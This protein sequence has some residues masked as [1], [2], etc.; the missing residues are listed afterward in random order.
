MNRRQFILAS[1]ASLGLVQTCFA[2]ASTLEVVKSPTCGCCDAWIEHMTRAGFRVSAQNLDQEALWKIKADSGISP[3]ISSCHT[4]F[5]DG[6]FIE[7]HVPAG[8]VQKLILERPSALGLSVPGMPIGS[9]GMEMGNRQDPY[10]TLLILKDGSH[11][12]FQS[13]LGLRI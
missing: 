6:Y 12:V 8:D 3:D 5:L 7:G 1:V 11:K 10:D 4:G 13:H 2:S 9:P